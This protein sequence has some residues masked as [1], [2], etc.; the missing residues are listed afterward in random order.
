MNNKKLSSKKNKYNRFPLIGN[1]PLSGGTVP[2]SNEKTAISSDEL[3]KSL[4]EGAK[5]NLFPLEENFSH[6]AI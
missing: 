5:R 1:I 6:C 4:R 2:L 3:L